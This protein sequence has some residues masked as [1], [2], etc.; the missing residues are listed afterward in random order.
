MYRG[1]NR[2]HVS[3]NL[4]KWDRFGTLL[5]GRQTSDDQFVAYHYAMIFDLFA[6]TVLCVQ[7]NQNRRWSKVLDKV[8]VP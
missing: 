5:G 3:D 7:I 8:N 2:F 6:L 4:A 1:K